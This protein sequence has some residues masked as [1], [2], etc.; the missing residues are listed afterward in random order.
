MPEMA[1]TTQSTPPTHV[2]GRAAA[3]RA[4]RWATMR[5][6]KWMSD[7]DQGVMS[8]GQSEGR[9]SHTLGGEVFLTARFRTGITDHDYW[10]SGPVMKLIEA[11]G[12]IGPMDG[13]GSW[14]ASNLS[15]RSDPGRHHSAC[16]VRSDI[17]GSVVHH[18]WHCGSREPMQ[19]G[20]FLARSPVILGAWCGVSEILVWWGK[21]ERQSG[22]GSPRPRSR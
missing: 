19:P 16:S 21:T 2:P 8:V 15:Q 5:R 10:G 13:V 18:P 22:S 1:L 3:S 20:D 6:P 4:G 9:L 12:D 17:A 14:A 11:G 7:P